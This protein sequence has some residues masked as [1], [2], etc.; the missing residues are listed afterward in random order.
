ML[1]KT[2]GASEDELA[3]E[4]ACSLDEEISALEEVSLLETVSLLEIISLLD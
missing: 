4:L 1:S 3:E 2:T